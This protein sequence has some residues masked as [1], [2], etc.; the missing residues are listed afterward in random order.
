MRIHRMVTACIVVGVGILPA[1]ESPEAPRPDTTLACTEAAD[2]E[3]SAALAQARA[4]WAAANVQD[5]VLEF[6]TLCYCTPT[7]SPYRVWVRAD[8]PIEVRDVNGVVVAPEVWAGW[9][10]T[11]SDWFD[12]T[13]DWLGRHPDFMSACFDADLGYPRRTS[14]DPD[15]GQADEEWSYELTIVH[16]N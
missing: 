9:R 16:R 3:V 4:Q 7:P 2:T 1:C 15:S 6:R 8:R 14:V 11:V 5:Y 10:L 12:E 13:E